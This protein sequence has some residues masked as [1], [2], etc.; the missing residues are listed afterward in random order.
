LPKLVWV[1]T[2]APIRALTICLASSPTFVSAATKASM[3]TSCFS[4][5]KLLSTSSSLTMVSA[6]HR[7]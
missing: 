5:R 6:T 4:A 3:A 2:E 1:G 7:A